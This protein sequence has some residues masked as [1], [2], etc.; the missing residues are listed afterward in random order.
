MFGVYN[1]VTI[2][3]GGTSKSTNEIERNN[4]RCVTAKDI[5]IEIRE[6]LAEYC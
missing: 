6:E 3:S 2:L 1:N 4:H 5:H